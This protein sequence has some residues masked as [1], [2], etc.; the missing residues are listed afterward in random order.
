MAALKWKSIWNFKARDLAGRD[1]VLFMIVLALALGGLLVLYPASSVNSARE[2]GDP[3]YY[4]KKQ[5]TW[6]LIGMFGLFIAASVP[7][8]TLRKLALPGMVL[9]LLLLL[10]VFVP[11]LGHSVS[12]SRES[13]NR[14]LQLGPFRFQPSEFAKIAVMVYLATILSREAVLRVEYDVRKLA[15]PIALTTVVL[16]AIILEPQYGTTVCM[17]GVIALLIYVSGFPMLRLMVVAVAS[18]PLLYLLIYYWDYR[19]DRFKVWLNP[20]EFRALGGYQLV[21]AWRAFREGGVLGEELA[22]GFGHRYL[23]FGHTDFIMALLA[24][25]FGYVGVLVLMAL[26]ILFLWRAYAMLRRVESPFPFM[27]GASALVM[28]I[29]QSLV[30]M[31]VV[32]G[33]LPTTGISLPFLSYG[34]SSLIVTLVFCG[35]ILNVSR[36]AEHP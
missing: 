11:G 33:L 22:A 23:P 15:P 1:M 8:E 27:L 25:D 7:L 13:F 20:Y 16:G 6:L 24:E 32:T 28:L 29:L 35:L 12:S 9:S 34:G 19:L 4:L 14:W 18:L 10:L 31:C 36:F 17:L 30:N 2:L 5:L 21:T 3:E 26:Y